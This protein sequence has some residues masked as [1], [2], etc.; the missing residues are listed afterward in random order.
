MMTQFS[1]ENFVFSNESSNYLLI[2]TLLL[3]ELFIFKT[4]IF[5]IYTQE[6]TQDT[7]NIKTKHFKKVYKTKL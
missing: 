5:L 7:S 3:R 4:F 2:F 1:K 6:P